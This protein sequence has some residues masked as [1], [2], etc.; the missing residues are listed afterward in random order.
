MIIQECL[1]QQIK[2]RNLTLFILMLVLDDAIQSPWNN[3]RIG[4]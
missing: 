1:L 4:L 2:F 3:L